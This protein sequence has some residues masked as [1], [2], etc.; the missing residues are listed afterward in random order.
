MF[1]QCEN[2]VKGDRTGNLLLRKASSDCSSL[3]G[4][5]IAAFPTRSNSLQFECVA[6]FDYLVAEGGGAL[7]F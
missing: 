4:M 5:R 1:A 3:G 6:Q 2:P 7:E